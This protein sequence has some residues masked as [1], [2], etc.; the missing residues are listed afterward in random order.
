MVCDARVAGGGGAAV[1]LADA[2]QARLSVPRES[3]RIV[4]ERDERRV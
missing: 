2:R 4:G 1:S 3:R